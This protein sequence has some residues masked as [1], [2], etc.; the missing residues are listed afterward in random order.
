MIQE[1]RRQTRAPFKINFITIFDDDARIRVCAEER[2]PIVSFHWGTPRIG[3][4]LNIPSAAEEVEQMMGAA[5]DILGRLSDAIRRQ[6][7][8]CRRTDLT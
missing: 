2:V 5:A 8:A 1:M 3:L 7:R 6:P 4:I